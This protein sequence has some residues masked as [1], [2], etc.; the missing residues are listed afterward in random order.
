MI[1]FGKINS[2][3][4]EFQDGKKA[5][6]PYE[7]L[8]KYGPVD[9]RTRDF[10][11]IEL[12]LLCPYGARNKL[13]SFLEKKLKR[14]LRN[15]FQI[16]K[17]ESEIITYTQKDFNLTIT[18]QELCEKPDD[19]NFKKI[20]LHYH[21]Y[22]YDHYD[23]DYYKIKR[24]ILAKGIPTQG[25]LR[26]NFTFENYYSN[27]IAIGIY[28]KLG[29]RPWAISG[30]VSEIFQKDTIYI[31][32][33]VSRKK[34]GKSTYEGS[35][36]VVVYDE[37]GQYVY[38]FTEH[39]PVNYDNLDQ[40]VAKSMLE[41]T[42][43]RFT[44]KKDRKPKNVVFIKDGDVSPT[45]IHGFK[46]ALIEDE[47]NLHIIE[48]PK[49]GKLPI[50]I[51]EDDHINL[52]DSGTFMKISTGY[53]SKPYELFIQNIGKDAKLP[54]MSKAIKIRPYIVKQS[55]QNIHLDR[56]I[57]DIARQIFVLSNLNWAYLKG[58]SNLP[59][60]V[61]YAHHAANLMRNGISPK[62]IDSMALWML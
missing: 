29:G 38:H 42:I 54:I 36:C 16:N 21:D 26:E 56:Y 33:D 53:P 17:I 46:D 55:E 49:R 20:V 51:F 12:K 47:T 28:A 3:I 9:Y 19:S 50:L 35:G 59:I 7:G 6:S 8:K 27:N 34:Y 13:N 5:S 10:Q 30:F 44:Q 39:F 15:L 23:A 52:S 40:N 62:N 4:Y 58:F 31:G 43:A 1:E 45:E 37:R 2:V 48:I 41:M 24:E 22:Y 32:F 57:N 61:H 18:N 60:V 14:S 11:N 25:L